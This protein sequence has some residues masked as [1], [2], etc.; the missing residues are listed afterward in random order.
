M[1]KF[2]KKI[3]LLSFLMIT[4]FIFISAFSFFIIGC[5][6]Q[7]NYN[8]SMID[9]VQRLKTINV[10]KII[11]TGNSNLSFGMNSQKL[12]EAIKM[13]VVNLGLH[14]G[15]G[16]VFSEEAAKLNV[17]EGD[18]VI[19]CHSDFSDNDA[20]SDCLL[21]WITVE[22]HK[23]LWEIIREKDY[24]NMLKAYPKYLFRSFILW[25]TFKGNKSENNTSYSR[26]AFNEFGDVIFKPENDRTPTNLLFKKGVINVPKINDICVK[27]INQLNKYLKNRGAILLIAG[28]PI[29]QGEFTPSKAEYIEFQK[30][31]S[32]KL[33]CEIISNYCDYFI[34][35]K[36][37]YN[38]R[39]HLDTHG[40]NIRTEKLINDIKNW[41]NKNFSK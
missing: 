27:R 28:Y 36:Y 4:S 18:I 23:D 17:N 9:K 12:Q 7:Q 10:P 29:A 24:L 33:E 19:L 8:A 32:T 38:A 6:Y 41:Q 30:E 39:L 3:L 1:K 35:Y 16:N 11:L 13:P 31:L 26:N 14:G 20:L 22:Y 34:P 21:A 25:A 37:F 5:Q 40:A 2:I 15:L